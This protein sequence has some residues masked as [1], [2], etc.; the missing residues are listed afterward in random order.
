MHYSDLS[1]PSPPPFVGEGL[2]AEFKAMVSNS[3]ELW[4][5]AFHEEAM[6]CVGNMAAVVD[7]ASVS[8]FAYRFDDWRKAD[9]KATAQLQQHVKELAR[10]NEFMGQ[11]LD[12]STGSGKLPDFKACLKQLSRLSGHVE[13]QR[14]RWSG[15]DTRLDQLQEQMRE[16]CTL[17]RKQSGQIDTLQTAERA[18]EQVRALTE[19][20]KEMSRVGLKSAEQLVQK[21]RQGSANDVETMK[22]HFEK[23]LDDGGAIRHAL[24]TLDER[25]NVWETATKDELRSWKEQAEG[26]EGKVAQLEEVTAEANRWQSAAEA[27]H[28]QNTGFEDRIH[29]LEARL[30]EQGGALERAAALSLSNGMRR[31]RDL[32]RQGNVRVNRQNGEV[33]LLKPVD[34]APVKPAATCP[35]A[36]FANVES[37]DKVLR[38]VAELLEVFDGAVEVEVHTKAAKGGTPVFWDEVVQGYAGLAR[39][40]LEHLG[41]ASERLEAKGLAGNK[42]LNNNCLV[43]R[44]DKSLFA[45]EA[46]TGKGGGK[47]GARGAS[48]GKGRAR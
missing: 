18:D 43:V 25:V 12:D 4:K 34:F 21:V 3:L 2:T 35:E 17:V 30:T 13:D 15:L 47:G 8:H 38:D 5:S 40:T 28:E 1:T 29:G 22:A 32:E 39:A 9:L 37:A 20:V 14:K 11:F 7:T 23:T 31:L 19:S 27:A 36:K 16:V 44:L 46:A 41:V 6:R 24:D 42:G 48:P 33:E 26:L 10:L 45:E